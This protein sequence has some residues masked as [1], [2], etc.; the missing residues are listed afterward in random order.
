MQPTRHKHDTS[1]TMCTRK[2]QPEEL[3]RDAPSRRTRSR[4]IALVLARL[5]PPSNGPA[6]IAASDSLPVA[7]QP[8]QTLAA[9]SVEQIGSPQPRFQPPQPPPLP[10][11]TAVVPLAATVQPVSP[12]TPLIASPAPPSGAHSSGASKIFAGQP[13]IWMES[14]C[15]SV[16]Q[17]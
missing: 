17:Q 5:G 7:P 2:R 12:H 10:P 9:A 11:A 14:V 3:L 13:Q 6:E 1:Q 15:N 4:S 16:E 8:A